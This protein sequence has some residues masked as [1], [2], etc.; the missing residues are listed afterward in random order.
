MRGLYQLDRRDNTIQTTDLLYFLMCVYFVCTF[1]I[2][3]GTQSEEGKPEMKFLQK[4]LVLTWKS[5]FK[6]QTD[7]HFLGS[8]HVA[9][10]VVQVVLVIFHKLAIACKCNV[11]QEKKKL[12]D[13]FWKQGHGQVK[14]PVES[15]R[16]SNW[17]QK[18][19]VTS[20]L[21]HLF[22]SSGTDSSH[23]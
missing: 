19:V 14:K 7:L 4:M 20:G 15:K 2:D 5:D 23:N 18:Q 6:A 8:P 22:K 12:W 10:G 3:R 21:N 11:L 16:V 9:D 1:L 13:F 17:T